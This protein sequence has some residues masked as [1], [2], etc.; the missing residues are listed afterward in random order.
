MREDY[1][2]LLTDF[3][4]LEKE[5]I[6]ARRDELQNRKAEVYAQSSRTDGES[7]MGAQK[8]LKFEEEQ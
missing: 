5:D 3:E 7:Y 8:A 2:S 4:I 1:V 6:M